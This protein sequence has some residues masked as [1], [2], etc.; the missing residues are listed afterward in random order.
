MSRVVLAGV[1][2]RHR[3]AQS[4]ISAS[5]R[6][7]FRRRASPS[8]VSTL[9]AH[10]QHL[11]VAQ[12]RRRPGDGT[13]QAAYQRR[14]S[15]AGVLATTYSGVLATA[16]PR[17]ASRRRC[18]VHRGPPAGASARGVLARPKLASQP[19]PGLHLDAQCLSVPQAFLSARDVSAHPRCNVASSHVSGWPASF[20][21]LSRR[22]GQHLS[23]GS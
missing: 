17:P 7:V 1:V 20:R 2:Y 4:G 11:R 5:S 18:P 16:R 9:R 15:L 8:G 3:S 10:D 14:R 23:R 19:I 22:P 21:G 13:L 12:Q 6:P